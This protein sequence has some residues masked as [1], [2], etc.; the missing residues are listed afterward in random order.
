VLKATGEE[1]TTM[2]SPTHNLL[3]GKISLH[4]QQYLLPFEVRIHHLSSE[5]VDA[6]SLEVF[7]ARLTGL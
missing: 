3:T 1:K 6:P 4:W 7:K 5:V 2:E